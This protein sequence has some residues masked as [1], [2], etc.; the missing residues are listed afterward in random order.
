MIRR[1]A[2]SGLVKTADRETGIAALLSNIQD[3][4]RRVRFFAAWQFQAFGVT[5]DSAIP[6][7]KELREDPVVGRDAARALSFIRVELQDVNK[8]NFSCGAVVPPYNPY[9]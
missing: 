1:F 5:A 6:K 3:P 9:K 8:P 4:D 2:A 7:L